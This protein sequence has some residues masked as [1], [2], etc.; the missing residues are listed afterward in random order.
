MSENDDK[1]LFEEMIRGNF[2]QQVVSNWIII[3][4][5]VTGESLELKIATSEGMTTWLATGM[6]NCAS[7]IVLNQGY[8]VDISEDDDD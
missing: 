1:A 3:I 8:G 4:E 7:D 6:L 2:P 5:T